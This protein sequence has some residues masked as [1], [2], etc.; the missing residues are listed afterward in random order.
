MTGL[1]PI[2]T[3]G[4]QFG[5]N[6]FGPGAADPGAPGQPTACVL[7]KAA[8]PRPA[9]MESYRHLRSALLLSSFGENRPQVLL[10]TSAS[11]GEG[12]TTIAINLA[13]LLARSGLRVVLVDAD[14]RSGCMGRLLGNQDQ[15]GVRKDLRGRRHRP[16]NHSPDRH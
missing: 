15:P 12:K 10:F 9:Y 6:V 13:R 1:S 14:G 2:T 8:T 7:G 3:S 11:P 5:G 16:G 4:D